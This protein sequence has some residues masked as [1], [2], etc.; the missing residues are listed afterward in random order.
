M[1]DRNIVDL[2][3]RLAERAKGRLDMDKLGVALTPMAEAIQQMRQLGLS[4][5]EIISTLKTA[6]DE[7]MAS[8]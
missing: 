8:D 1:D 7:I 2:T 5:A 6:L 4:R 3:A